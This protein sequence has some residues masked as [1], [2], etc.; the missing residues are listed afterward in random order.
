MEI[1]VDTPRPRVKVPSVIE[2]KNKIRLG[3]GECCNCCCCK[4]PVLAVYKYVQPEIPKSFRPIR[5]FQRTDIP[6]E[7]TT[8]YRMSFW[9]GPRSVRK[10]LIRYGCLA[11]AEGKITSDTTHKLSYLGNWCIK[12]QEKILPCKR[13]L[14]GRGPIENQT[15]QK[16]DFVWKYSLKEKPMKYSG[17]LRMPRGHIEDNTTYKS[18]Y[19]ESTCNEPVKSFKP[20]RLYEKTEVPLDDYTTYKLSF[21]NNDTVHREEHPWQ[22]KP[23]YV[24]PSTRVDNCTTYKLSYWPQCEPRVKPILQQSDDNPLNKRNFSFEGETTYGLSYFGGDGDKPKPIYPVPN[25]IFVNQSTDHDTVNKMSYLGNWCPSPVKPI[26]PCVRKLL[27]RGPIEKETTQKCDFPWKFQEPNASIRPVGNLGFSSTPLENCTTN[28]LS[29]L[30]NSGDCL[31]PKKSFAP[32]RT[33][34][35]LDLPMDLDTTMQ[36]SYQPVE[37]PEKVDKPW[38]AKV[39]YYKPATNVDDNTTYTMSYIPPGTLH[40]CGPESSNLDSYAVSICPSKT[41]PYIPY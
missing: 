13:S 3:H 21:F 41:L 8:T 35:P 38:A 7:D 18:S 14:F 16:E 29:Y 9:P 39:P 10:P 31:I 15:T 19:F 26:V 4:A 27:G 6:L 12:P 36:L 34:D 32:I 28:R 17:N 30:P 40:P 22:K 24:K 1:H 33:Y 23:M 5:T 20:I 37:Q 11:T 2:I 25:E